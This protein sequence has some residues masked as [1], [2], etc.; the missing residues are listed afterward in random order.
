MVR[1]AQCWSVQTASEANA[2]Q[3]K[4]EP[5]LEM[6]CV[7]PACGNQSKQA[8]ANSTMAS[9]AINLELK[10][11]EPTSSATLHPVDMHLLLALSPLALLL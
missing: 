4:E 5:Q 1:S 6:G 10:V 3:C 7:Q 8:P 11:Q 2:E 9:D